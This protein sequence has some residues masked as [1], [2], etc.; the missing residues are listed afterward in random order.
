MMTQLWPEGVPIAVEVGGE[1]PGVVHWQG[2]RA[3]RAVVDQWIIHDEWW[4][5]SRGD[6]QGEIWRHYFQL[7][8]VDGL[9]CVIYRD[10]LRNTWHLERVYD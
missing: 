4:R 10:L 2:R 7:Q 5:N 1:R 9:L 3:V 8:T 6:R